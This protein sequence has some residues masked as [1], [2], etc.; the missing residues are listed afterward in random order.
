MKLHLLLKRRATTLTLIWNIFNRTFVI[1]SEP[2]NVEIPKQVLGKYKSVFYRNRHIFFCWR[3]PDKFPGGISNVTF[4]ETPESRF[5]RNSHFINPNPPEMFYF[6]ITQARPKPEIIICF[7]TQTLNFLEAI[8]EKI[9]L[10]ALFEITSKLNFSDIRWSTLERVLFNSY[11][12]EMFVGDCCSVHNDHQRRLKPDRN[13][14]FSK[15]NPDL[16]L[17]YSTRTWTHFLNANPSGWK[18]ETRLSLAFQK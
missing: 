18:P 17:L 8:F 13:L 4:G 6:F 7:Q 9:L 5:G 3:F 11:L 12:A 10:K 15:P 1:I 14:T 2:L 16:N